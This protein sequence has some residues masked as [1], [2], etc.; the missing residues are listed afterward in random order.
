MKKALSDLL[1]YTLLGAILLVS[2]GT[3]LYLVGLISSE[4]PVF[5]A[6]VFVFL[7]YLLVGKIALFVIDKRRK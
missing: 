5:R 6:L 2:V 3:L 1:S 7:L 4:Y